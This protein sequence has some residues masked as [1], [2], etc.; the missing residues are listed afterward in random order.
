MS[1]S[2][3]LFVLGLAAGAVLGFLASGGLTLFDR[4]AETGK[5]ADRPTTSNSAHKHDATREA[6]PNA[7]PV[8]SLTVAPETPCT[9]NLTIDVT[10]FT[11]APVN[12]NGPHVDGEG[13]A[14]LYAGPTKLA[15]VYGP[16][17]HATAPA[18]STEISVTLNTNDHAI[19]TH[20][21][22][23]ITAIVPLD[24]C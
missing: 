19:Y 11:F 12:V 4:D 8:L 21:D 6:P 24:G 16:H 3:T 1:K 10:N 17:F 5:A 22:Q 20:N 15:R 14:H 7:V 13:H 9:F 2:N 23:P 18:G